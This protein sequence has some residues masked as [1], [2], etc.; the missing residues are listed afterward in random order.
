MNK[1]TDY[2]AVILIGAGSSYGRSPDKEEAIRMALRSVS[3]WRGMFN[4]DGVE[5]G[6]NVVDVS[7]YSSCSWGAYPKNW[8][9][10]VNEATG[11]DEP[12]MRDV[13]VIKRT[14]PARKKRR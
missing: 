14:T 10:G 13:E 11:V 4:V 3:D 7:G 1:V 5:F 8:L 2:L 12:I 9:W 6:I